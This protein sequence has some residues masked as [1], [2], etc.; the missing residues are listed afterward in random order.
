MD[1]RS[2]VG[3]TT[4]ALQ[5]LVPGGMRGFFVGIE[6]DIHDRANQTDNQDDECD[7]RE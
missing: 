2:N 3:G 5:P 6:E 1:A 7:T 4:K